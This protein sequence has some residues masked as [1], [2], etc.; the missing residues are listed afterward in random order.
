M[1]YWTSIHASFTVPV[2]A[3]LSVELGEAMGKALQKLGMCE[4]DEVEITNG[5]GNEPDAGDV[6]KSLSLNQ[7]DISKGSVKYY[8]TLLSFR[9]LKTGAF[10]KRL[11]LPIVPL[12]PYGSEGGLSVTSAFDMEYDRLHVSM[13]G[14]LRDFEPEDELYIKFWLD[15]VAAM[16]D[17]KILYTY[18][19]G[20]KDN[21]GVIEHE[22]YSADYSTDEGNVEESNKTVD[23][24]AR[25]IRYWM[26]W[27]ASEDDGCG[28]ESWRWFVD[29]KMREEE[30]KTAKKDEE[31]S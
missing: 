10:V 27:V 19:N 25:Y 13:I 29:R 11:D 8:L 28:H 3:P 4:G 15:T 23:I 22:F 24:L 18:N 12:S 5:C 9:D 7:G 6:I 2:K 1:S 26:E 31:K 30:E 14:N 17:T 20:D 16:L 21:T